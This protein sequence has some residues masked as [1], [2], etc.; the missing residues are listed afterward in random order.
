MQMTSY[1]IRIGDWSSD[2]CS[3][4]LDVPDPATRVERRDRVL[5][6]HLEAR[7]GLAELLATELREVGPVEE[8]LAA[9]RLRELHDGA[10]RRGLA[11]AGL[12]D[13]PERLALDDVDADPG[14]GLDRGAPSAGELHVELI[15]AQQGGGSEVGGAGAGHPAFCRERREVGKE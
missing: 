2:V 1:E 3:S 12:A 6:D 14:D 10:T 13:E 15:A 11:A 7:P 9:G 8:H 5:E 4:D